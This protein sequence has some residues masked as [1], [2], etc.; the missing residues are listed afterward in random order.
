MALVH[1]SDWFSSSYLH[2]GEKETIEWLKD[3]LSDD[4]VIWAGVEWASRERTGVPVYGEIDF[5]VVGPSGNVVLVEQKNGWLDIDEHGE[6][7]KSY[8]ERRKS[9][10]K[11]LRHSFSAFLRQWDE[12]YGRDDLRPFVTTLML[13]PDFTVQDVASLQVDRMQLVDKARLKQLPDII[14]GILAHS[15]PNPRKFARM[16]EFLEG[17]LAL[18]LD[19]GAALENQDKVYRSYGNRLSR[20]VETLS[21]APRRLHV[22]GSAGSG[23]TQL[24]LGVYARALQ[25]G[26]RVLYLCF[27]RPLADRLAHILPR[28]PHGVDPAATGLAGSTATGVVATVDHL[29]ERYAGET[30]APASSYQKM[31]ERFRA[32]RERALAQPVDPRWQFDVVIVDEG[33]DFSAQQAAFVELLLAPDGEL[34]WMADARQQLYARDDTAAL[35]TTLRMDL[36]ENFRCGRAIVEYT[37]TLL[38]LQPPDIAAAATQGELPQLHV[39]APG[40]DVTQAVEKE[41]RRLLASGYE[42]GDI[43][44][45]S[46]MGMDRSHLVRQP[47]LAGWHTRRFEGY[48]ADGSQ[49]YSQGLLRVDTVYRFKGL[50]AAAVV[51]AEI[52]IGEITPSVLNRLY[53]GMTRA[54]SAL[55]LIVSE[56][57]RDLLLANLERREGSSNA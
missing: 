29:T 2:D 50:Q 23:K 42:A 36:R 54:R 53:T 8:G 40:E 55:S 56:R 26:Q 28:R 5:L 38:A 15:P 24:A 52:D 10:G 11:Q 33:Q 41:I 30:S 7:T 44:V 48:D 9:V 35:D 39:L 1:P 18:T 12:A 22:Q 16:M 51:F 13:L 46:G 49:R 3:A 21:F 27:N 34:L 43:A 31:D 6:L 20:F 45:I 25:R 47:M 14:S 37:N 4:H 19:I 57:T 32:L 17:Q